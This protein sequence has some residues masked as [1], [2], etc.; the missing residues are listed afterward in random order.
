M[1]VRLIVDSAVNLAMS[2]GVL[3]LDVIAAF[4][5][6]LRRIIFNVEEGDEQWLRSLKHAGF[7]EPAI[8]SIYDHVC[9][10]EWVNQVLEDISSKDPF[11][12]T[13]IDFNL[14]EQ[15][16]TNSWVSQDCIPNVL[17]I[18]NGSS[19]GTPLA[20]LVY[21]LC[22]ARVLSLLRDS[23]RAD[24]LSSSIAIGG[25]HFDVKDVSYVDDVAMPV[26]APACNLMEKV[27]TI[28]NCAYAVFASFGMALNFNPGKSE[29]TVGFFGPGSRAATRKLAKNNSTISIS[30]G[31]FSCLNV[32]KS[33]QHVGT[34]SPISCNPGEEV[35]KRIGIMRSDSR[36]LC[37]KILKI[38]EIPMSKKINVIQTFVLTRG[39]FQCG[40]WPALSDVQYKRFHGSILKLYR[41][42]TGNSFRYKSEDDDGAFD[43]TSMFNDDDIIYRYMF[44]CPKT[45]L[46]LARLLLFVRIIIKTPPL[47][48]E[49]AQAHDMPVFRKGWVSSLK[50]DLFWLSSAEAFSSC[51]SFS[52]TQW[53]AFLAA[54]PGRYLKQIKAFCK[55]P[56]A[57]I[58]TQWAT[59]S[60]LKQY[61]SPIVCYI[62]GKESNSLQAHS[63]HL[64]SSHNI[65]SK[66]RRYVDGATCRVCLRNFSS[67]ECCLN[68][69]RYRSKVCYANAL[70]RGPVL[71]IEE[72]DALD[73]QERSEYQAL[74]R[75]GKRRHV[76]SVPCMQAHGPL[77]PII[78]LRHSEHHPLGYGHNRL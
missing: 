10:H 14:M 6:L 26:L 63:V 46:R 17:N 2:C 23:L 29:C 64:S 73:Q 34:L 3:Y 4:A 50:S 71:T 43:V 16:Y 67:R 37:K 32:V 40:T 69:V 42:A 70:M 56:F 59:S 60:V 15:F 19:A 28:A 44:M 21:G 65:K 47:L 38:P 55:S 18:V 57:N 52:V 76:A 66:F 30:A 12:P 7:D 33:Y 58:C 11:D 20:D 74:H 62:C 39:T 51:G 36:A 53:V 45:M 75:A 31:D 77:L 1:Y 13:A 8:K 25:K 27:A 61:S 22:M 5:T 9:D 78:T 48:L 24:K 49:L 68:H 72:A 35:T 41:D 54:A